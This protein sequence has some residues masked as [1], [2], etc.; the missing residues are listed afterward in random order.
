MMALRFYYLNDSF[1]LSVNLREAS[2]NVKKEGLLG[3]PG[4]VDDRD[5]VRVV[6]LILRLALFLE[7]V[8]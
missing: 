2:P 4:G 1:R 3:I 8:H 5:T 7:E 6:R